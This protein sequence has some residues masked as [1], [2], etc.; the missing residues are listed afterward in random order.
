M[1]SVTAKKYFTNIVFATKWALLVLLVL[2]LVLIDEILDEKVS[3]DEV[4]EGKD[5]TEPHAHQG[6]VTGEPGDLREE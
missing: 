3:K 6:P 4:D 1:L 2:V 5:D